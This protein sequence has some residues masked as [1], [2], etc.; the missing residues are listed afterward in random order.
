[1]KIIA[2]IYQEKEKVHPF[3]EVILR[4]AQNKIEVEKPIE[5]PIKKPIEN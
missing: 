3:L 5:K 4:I 1:M 2:K